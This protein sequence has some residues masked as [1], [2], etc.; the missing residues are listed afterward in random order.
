MQSQQLNQLAQ[1]QAQQQALG[2][3]QFANQFNQQ[4]AQLAAQ[5]GL[6]G[7]QAAEQSR[8]FG[9]GMGMQGIQQLL[10]AGAQMNQLGQTQFGQQAASAQAQQQAG[11]IQQAQTQQGL[12][13][14]YEEFMRQQFYPQSQ[15]QFYSSLLR[16]VPVSPQQTQYSYQAAP[17]MASQIGGLAGGLFST[18]KAFGAKN[19]GEVPGYAEGGITGGGGLASNVSKMVKLLMAS[20]N[21]E[22]DII[23]MGGT[24]LEQAMALEKVRQMRGAAQN[25][26]ALQGGQPQGTV[27][28]EMGLGGLDVDMD[29]ADGGIVAFTNGGASSIFGG[30]G[31]VVERRKR[32]LSELM[33][34]L[35]A[36]YNR[37]RVFA[38]P[39]EEARARQLEE[40]KATPMEVP[41]PAGLP[42]ALPQQAPQVAMDQAAQNQRELNRLPPPA[43]KPD[44][45]QRIPPARAAATAAP[46]V[47]SEAPAERT[48]LL[49]TGKSADEAFKEK[50]AEMEKRFPSEMKERLAEHKNEAQQ[51]L[52]ERDRDG[53][54]AAAAG[55]FAAGAGS[56]PYALKNFAE[57]AGVAV[58][59]LMVVNKDF[60]KAED[61]RN[62]AIREERR[63]DRLEQMQ[64]FDAAAKARTR[65][66]DTTRQAQQADAM[67]EAKLRG[68]ATSQFAAE[69]R[70]RVG[71]AQVGASRELAATTRADTLFARNVTA[72]NTAVQNEKNSLIKSNPVGAATDPQFESKME[73][74]AIR[75]IIARNPQFAELAGVSAGTAQPGAAAPMQGWG[76]ASV[77]GR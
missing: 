53:W 61:L 37:P 71:M 44:M 49:Y 27:L 63:A 18:A 74:Q 20:Q 76:K 5:Y 65:V 15:L 51:A 58:K 11:A 77:V 67:Y 42:A 45:G 43:P 50:E 32:E 8:Q 54:L 2:Q 23:K 16:G 39:A 24:R 14:N 3:N 13:Q 4:N 70:E 28:D 29:Y 60:R 6:S 10:G 64:K 68:L 66:E 19:G 26:Q 47:K 52:K 73:Q 17:S 72:Y 69:S 62:K 75:N 57:G 22:Q 21:P 59:E 12:D 35:R 40:L 31:D 36:L 48:S 46:A 34:P 9:A 30:L 38:T 33:S 25:Q 1:L 7:L 56:S 41:A 55:F